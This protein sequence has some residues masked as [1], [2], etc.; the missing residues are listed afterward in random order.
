MT[1]S[2]AKPAPEEVRAELKLVLTAPTFVSSERLSALLRFIVEETL[3]GRSNELK[4]YTLGGEVFERGAGFAP[5]IAPI[6]RV[7]A[8]KL[9][10]KLLEYYEGPGVHDGVRISVP[11]G[12]YV[13]VFA[14]ARV[15]T[16]ARTHRW[17]YAA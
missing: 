17:S 7:S 4:E 11:K 12:S 15:S 8:G 14:G 5:K 2:P 13:P 1:D 9:R 6:V 16:R 10:H 3:A